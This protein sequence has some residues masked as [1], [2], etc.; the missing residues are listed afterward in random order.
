MKR[1]VALIAVI[2]AGGLVPSASAGGLKQ[3]DA[4]I[5]AAKHVFQNSA[6]FF[7]GLSRLDCSR[8]TSNRFSCVVVFDQATRWNRRSCRERV[9]VYGETDPSARTMK[10]SCRV[11]NAPYLSEYQARRRAWRLVDPRFRST[12]NTST[13]GS[14]SYDRNRY[15]FEFSWSSAKESCL[16]TIKVALVGDSVKASVGEAACAPAVPWPR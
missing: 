9:L 10:R 15:E 6:R 3:N 8:V 16:Q 14:T 2:L 12:L 13:G 7:D 11:L 5:A 4:R 1:T